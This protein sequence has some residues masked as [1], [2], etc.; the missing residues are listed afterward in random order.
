MNF[1]FGVVIFL[2]NVFDCG[3]FYLLFL[4]SFTFTIKSRKRIEALKLVHLSE[5]KSY[6][7][8]FHYVLISK[9]H[10]IN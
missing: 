5:M 8:I 9:I 6:N 2:Q 3:E 1:S 4:C 10:S 7:L